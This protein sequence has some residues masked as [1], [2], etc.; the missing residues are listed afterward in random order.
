MSSMLC[1]YILQNQSTKGG[2]NNE[3][4]RAGHDVAEEAGRGVE[5]LAKIIAAKFALNLNPRTLL[6]KWPVTRVGNCEL[7]TERFMRGS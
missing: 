1:C 2:P 6:G 7:M 3:I 4:V 5:V